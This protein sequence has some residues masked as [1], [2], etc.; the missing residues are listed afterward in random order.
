MHES[1]RFFRENK[2]KVKKVIE[3]LG[4]E[5]SKDC[6]K[7]MIKFRCTYNH[8]IL[9]V[10]SYRSQYFDNPYFTYNHGEVFIDC[11]AF[12]RDTIQKFKK[13]IAKQGKVYK[14]IIA[15]ESDKR[16]RLNLVRIHPDVMLVA[17]G[18]W[19]QNTYLNFSAGNGEDCRIQSSES[20]EQSVEIIQA[21]ALDE[22][23]ECTEATFVKMD[24]EG[25]EQHALMGLQK[26]IRSNQPKMAIS[27]YHSDADM[28]EIPL[29]IKRINPSYRFYVMQHTNTAY[30][31]VLYVTE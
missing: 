10:N 15:V 17:D 25:A 5:Q 2:D 20:N 3:M 18:A 28:V 7:R 19:D 24:I 1:R 23:S 27:I 26:T 6:Y 8:K 14:R 31:T 11:G 13:K 16:N 9:P 30:E 29:M 12:D 21:Y 4:D 22:I